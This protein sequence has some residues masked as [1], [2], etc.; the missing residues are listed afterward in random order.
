MNRILERPHT[1]PASLTSEAPSPRADLA[2]TIRR[3]AAAELLREGK[4]RDN[5]TPTHTM[6]TADLCPSQGAKAAAGFVQFL[7]QP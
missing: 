6:R 2:E 1:I 4:A 5:F 3:P 7:S